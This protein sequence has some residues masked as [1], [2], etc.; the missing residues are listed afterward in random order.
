[1]LIDKSGWNFQRSR[2]SR[3]AREFHMRMPPSK[4]R[5]F[6]VSDPTS[7]TQLKLELT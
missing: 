7:P 1:M 2:E 3:S 4:N 5:S 6:E